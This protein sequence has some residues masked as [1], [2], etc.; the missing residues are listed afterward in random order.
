MKRKEKER[1]EV[2]KIMRVRKTKTA[3]DRKGKQ[4]EGRTLGEQSWH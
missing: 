3:T 2:R 1:G 4:Q